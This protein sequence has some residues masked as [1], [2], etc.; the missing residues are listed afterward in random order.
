MDAVDLNPN[1][2]ECHCKGPKY[3]CTRHCQRAEPDVRYFIITGYGRT[4]LDASSDD[5]AVRRVEER[6][7]KYP[8]IK[9]LRI[10]KEIREELHWHRD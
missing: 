4:R 5:E 10:I 1:W 9:N 7:Q 8:T 3:I 2:Q 6:M